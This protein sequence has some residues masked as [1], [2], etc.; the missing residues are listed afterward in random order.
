MSAEMPDQW[1]Y[2][3]QGAQ[4]GPVPMA[5]LRQMLAGGQ[6]LW[7]EMVWTA[8]MPAW[9]SAS[10]V[11]ALR[12]TAA[13][14]PG[15]RPPPLPPQAIHYAAPPP[16]A[17]GGDIGADA[18]MRMLLPVGRSGWAIAAG[19]L[20]LFSVLVIFAPISLIVSIIAIRDI[21]KHDKRGMGRAI[22]GLIMGALFTVIPLAAIGMSVL[23]ARGR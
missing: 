9:S 13:T 11:S 14:S 5:T 3:R 7:S 8:G 21:R 12:P 2:S 6:V 20:G 10:S 19:Y 18:T 23:G 1:F 17:S 16:P 15:S 4:R 22:F